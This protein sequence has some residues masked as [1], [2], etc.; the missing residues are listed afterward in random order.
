MYKLAKVLKSRI[1][2][3]RAWDDL[4]LRV[5]FDSETTEET[6]GLKEKRSK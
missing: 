1:I 2:I 6:F 3:C 5:V 4:R